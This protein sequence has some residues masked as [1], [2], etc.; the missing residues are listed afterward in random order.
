MNEFKWIEVIIDL[1]LYMEMHMG[2]H[3]RLGYM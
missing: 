1:F 3:M 2:I